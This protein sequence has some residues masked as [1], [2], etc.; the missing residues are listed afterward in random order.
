[1]QTTPFL[2]SANF[3]IGAASINFL[4]AGISPASNEL[5]DSA[6]I[7]PTNENTQNKLLFFIKFIL[8][9]ILEVFLIS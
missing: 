6:V 5:L 8:V 1:M 4:L 2:N 7:I 9:N 3:V